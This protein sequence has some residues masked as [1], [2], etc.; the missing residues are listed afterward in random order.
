VLGLKIVQLLL[1]VTGHR[2]RFL[3]ALKTV[4][5]AAPY[6]NE[7]DSA[8]LGL[9]GSAGFIFL[10]G[11]LLY[12]RHTRQ[13]PSLPDAL[14]LLN[15]F[16]VLLGTVGGLGTLIALFFPWI[17]GYNRI[18][19]YIGFFCLF[20]V[21][22]LLERLRKHCNS[23]GPRRLGFHALLLLLLVAGILDQNAKKIIFSYAYVHEEYRND[24]DFFH[25]IE[26]CATANATIF[27]LPCVPFPEDLGCHG[28]APYSHTRAYYATRTL[29]WS[30]GAMKGRPADRWQQQ[31]IALPPDDMARTLIDAG[32]SGIYLDRFGY[33]DHGADLEDQFTRVL[34]TRPIVSDNER[35]VYFPLPSTGVKRLRDT[36][37]AE[38]WQARTEALQNPMVFTWRGGFSRRETCGRES[39]HWCSGEGEL[40]IL[41]PLPRPRTLTL[42][43]TCQTG[44]PEPALLTM[45]GASL[46]DKRQI[47]NR[48][49]EIVQSVTVQ[50]GLNA[51]HFTCDARPLHAPGD[52]RVL[53][54][55]VSRFFAREVSGAGP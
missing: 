40:Q 18:S 26:A 42:K 43:M 12:R 31:V 13:G 9:I 49:E 6:V 19:V 30:Y 8:A 54:F 21:V 16:A 50:P 23:S 52:P 41:N 10:L 36:F 4:Y 27:Q 38:E 5:N 7:N 22:L 46:S 2:L 11:R 32:F 37:S 48:S 20:A 28:M 39:W 15:A 24:V 1:P 29:R 45:Q 14:A 47:N 33:E 55:N 34:G 53:V 44:H 17:R 51:I 3:A 35:L 25:K